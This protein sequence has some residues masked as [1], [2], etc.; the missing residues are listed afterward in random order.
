MN[1]T[2]ATV[3]SVGFTLAALLSAGN[4]PAIQE[5]KPKTQTIE[6]EGIAFEIPE[7][8]KSIQPKS[9]MRKA[10]I[11]IAASAGDKEGGDLS[12]YIFPGG[13]GGVDANVERWRGQFTDDEGDTPPVETARVKSK[14]AEVT[15]VEVGGTFKDPFA[16]GGPKEG[17]RLLGAIVQNDER[18]YYFKLVGPDKTVKAAE[19]DFDAMIESIMLK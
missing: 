15:R 17:F 2:S 16:P 19:K 8:W 13:A 10:Q 18:G 9:A 4:G 3:I 14:N 1:R 6:A 5:E 7:S 11:Q 12:L